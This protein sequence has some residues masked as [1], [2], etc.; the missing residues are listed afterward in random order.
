M[1]NLLYCCSLPDSIE[2]TKNEPSK[3]LLRLYGD[4]SRGCDMSIQLEIFN[5]LSS[6]DLGPKL[7]GDFEDGRLEEFLPAD[8][9][10][11]EELMDSDISTVIAKKLARVHNLNPPIDKDETWLFNRLNDWVKDVSQIREFAILDGEMPPTSSK[12]ADQLLSIDYSAE[13]KFLRDILKNTR[14]PIVFSHNDLHQGNILLASQSKSRPTLEERVVFIDFEYSS[15]NNRAFDIANHFCEWCF[16]YDTPE[17]PHFILNKDR[18]PSLEAQR[19]FVR[20]YLDE[21]IYYNNKKQM[22]NGISELNGSNN[23]TNN[24]NKPK[25]NGNH[26]N[27]KSV[28]TT[29]RKDQLENADKLLIEVKPYLMAVNLHWSLWCIKT[30]QNSSIKF[31]YLVS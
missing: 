28:D 31:G 6:K 13:I 10:T 22:K 7:Y 27:G 18:F 20:H 14:S 16:Q 26:L 11:C 15:Y 25:V 17:F 5:L 30:A 19:N 24:H 29:S 4:Q 9:L 12:V 2:Q 8:S 23:H 3:V 21:F 1:S